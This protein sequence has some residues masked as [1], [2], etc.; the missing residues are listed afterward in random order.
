MSKETFRNEI[1]SQLKTLEPSQ[2]EEKSKRIMNRF[3]ATEA[4]KRAHTIGITISRFP[5]VNT[6]PIIE[7][8]WVAGKKVAVPK[9]IHSTRHMDFRY[10]TSF[11]QLEKAY[12][13]LMEPKVS[14]TLSASKR[15][16]DLLIV[17][18]VVFSDEGYRIGFGGGYYDRYLATYRGNY[19]SLAFTCQTGHSV[20]M[21]SHDVPV[22]KIITEEKI[23]TCLG[24]SRNDEYSL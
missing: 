15:E 12:V 5:E 20:P 6:Q 16:I 8:A 19:L 3:I 1:L 23:I 14:E 4:F 9:C 17:P 7:A 10:I 24:V 2:Y 22:Q 11:N 18:G 13:G 21:E